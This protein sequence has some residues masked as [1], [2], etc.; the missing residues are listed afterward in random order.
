MGFRPS[1][2]LRKALDDAVAVSG[3]SLSQEIETRIERTFLEDQTR[4]DDFG[5]RDKYELGRLFAVSANRLDPRLRDAVARL[6]TTGHLPKSDKRK[7]AKLTWA[8][9]WTFFLFAVVYWLEIAKRDYFEMPPG[10]ED[11]EA[12]FYGRRKPCLGGEGLS[13]LGALIR[14]WMT[15]EAEGRPPT[16]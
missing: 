10:L 7:A 15:G 8:N 9:D 16:K 11:F 1:L 4:F 6:R 5:G 12:A 13:E 14:D 3:Q 2:T